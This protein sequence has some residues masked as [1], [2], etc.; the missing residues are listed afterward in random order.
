[1][2]AKSKENAKKYII[3]CRVDDHEMSMLKQRAHQDG[4]S[5]TQ[6][7]RSCLDIAESN[8]RSQAANRNYACG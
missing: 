1:M 5:I 3:S 7:L 8:T 2:M 6:L 4:I